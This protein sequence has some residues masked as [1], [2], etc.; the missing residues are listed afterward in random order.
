[1][2]VN[3]TKACKSIVNLAQCEYP[4]KL[5]KIK[6]INKKYLSLLILPV[7]MLLAWVIHGWL[8]GQYLQQQLQQQAEHMGVYSHKLVNALN[9]YDYLPSILIGNDALFNMASTN[10]DEASKQL[11]IIREEAGADTIFILSR[12]GTTVASSNWGNENSL[13][14]QSFHNRL[15]SA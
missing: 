5:W 12:N 6:D 7:L 4:L 10:P 9:R 14:G 2:K 11:E 15:F 8:K 3:F 13:V 1:L